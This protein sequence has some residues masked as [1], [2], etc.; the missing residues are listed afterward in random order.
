MCLVFTR[1]SRPFDSSLAIVCV[2]ELNKYLYLFILYYIILY[3]IEIFR[4]E[5]LQ[6]YDIQQQQQ[7]CMVNI[8]CMYF[9]S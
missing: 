2:Y 7:K 6:Q 4:F 5:I 9:F 1:I 3:Y 8:F